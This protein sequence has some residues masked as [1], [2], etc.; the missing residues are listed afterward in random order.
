MALGLTDATV[1]L[2]VDTLAGILGPI[3]LAILVDRLGFGWIHSAPRF[4]Q[5]RGRMH[6]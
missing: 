3:V 4:L 6:G 2:I 1:H 5:T